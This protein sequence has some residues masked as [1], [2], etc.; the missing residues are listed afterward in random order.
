MPGDDLA[1]RN[2]VVLGASSGIGRATAIEAVGH[3]ANALLCGRRKDHL[4]DVQAIACGG[5]VC[6]VDI[7]DSL[8]VERLAEEVKGFGPVNALVS[9]VGTSPLK[10]V[11]QMTETDWITVMKNN[12]IGINRV[13]ASLL[14][15]FADGAMVLAFSTEAVLMPRWAMAAYAASKAALEVSLSGWRREHS[16]IRFGTVVVGGT[17]PTDFSRDFD[18]DLLHTALE[19]WTRHGQT[20]EALMDPDEVGRVVV[21]LLASLLPSPGVNMEHVVLRTPSPIVGSS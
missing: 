13:V 15:S 11:E 2:V 9:T 14:P 7:S 20:T 16:R 12:V 5:T 4:D 3:G 10:R 1:G 8:G 6:Q 17:F 21:G 19:T 18:L